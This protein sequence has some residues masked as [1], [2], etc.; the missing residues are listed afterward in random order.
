METNNS[1]WQ[2]IFSVSARITPSIFGLYLCTQPDN[3]T[4]LAGLA[5]I[6]TSIYLLTEY[7]ATKSTSKNQTNNQSIKTNNEN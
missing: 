2:N 1:L 6:F 4:V 7:I 3:V 5:M